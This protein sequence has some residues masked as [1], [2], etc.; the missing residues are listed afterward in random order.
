MARRID[1]HVHF[2]VPGQNDLFWMVDALKPTLGRPFLPEDLKPH[3][4]LHGIDGVIKV[5]AGRTHADNVWWLELADRYPYVA[6]VIGW[7][8]CANPGQATDWL[9]EFCSNRKFLGVRPMLEE[10]RDDGWVLQPAV[11]Q[12]IRA[13]AERDLV[14]EL[15]VLTKHLPHVA[16]IAADHPTLRVNVNHLA[17]PALFDGGLVAWQ[18]AIE[19]VAA[20]PNV[21]F[22]VSALVEMHQVRHGRWSVQEAVAPYARFVRA[23]AGIDRCIWA[24][25]WPVC[26]LAGDYD[27]TLQS[28]RDGI[29]ELSAEDE[30]KLFGANA[31]RFYRV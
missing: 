11:Q 12:T 25:D 22:K 23:V 1:P 31:A 27:D 28:A 5:Q 26:L 24:S 9:D 15:L 8:D 3:L 17:K 13:L 10:E 30:A 20:Y 2:W 14:L 21:V 29:G 6:G 4:D 16:R 7:V 18:R 19:R